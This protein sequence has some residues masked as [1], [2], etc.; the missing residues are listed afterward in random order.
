[1]GKR[2]DGVGACNEMFQT[3]LRRNTW[4]KRGNAG[5]IKFPLLLLLLLFVV[6]VVV[7]FSLSLSLLGSIGK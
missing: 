7:V 5:S 6:V 1:M 3:F 4:E 2:S